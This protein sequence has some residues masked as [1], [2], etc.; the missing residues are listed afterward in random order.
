MIVENNFCCWLKQSGE[1]KNIRILEDG[2][3][4]SDSE[5]KEQLHYTNIHDML[6]KDCFFSHKLPFN[7]AKGRVN[8]IF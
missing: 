3:I 8:F 6:N 5:P 1:P 2:S 7:M 4:T